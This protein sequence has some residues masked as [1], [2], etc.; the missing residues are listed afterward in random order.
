MRATRKIVLKIRIQKI[1]PKNLNIILKK[2]YSLKTT[3][4]NKKIINNGKSQ[5]ASPK[6]TNNKELKFEPKTPKA[7]T[8]GSSFTVNIEGS[9]SLWVYKDTDTIN[10]KKTQTKQIEILYIVT[11]NFESILTVLLSCL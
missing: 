4:L 10:P 2:L 7:F 9:K 3:I 1:T 6:T 11:F 8:G 5:E